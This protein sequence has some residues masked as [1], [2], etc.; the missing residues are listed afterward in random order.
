M[1]AML[2]PILILAL[3]LLAA[4]FVLAITAQSRARLATAFAELESQRQSELQLQAKL[5]EVT[6]S[7]ITPINQLPPEAFWPSRT[8]ADM[9]RA[10]QD[11]VLAAAQA[12]G[13]TVISFGGMGGDARC[14]LPCLTYEAELSGGHAEVADFLAAIE[15]V[16]PMLSTRMVWMRQLP[17][18]GIRAIA[19]INMRVSLWGLAPNIATAESD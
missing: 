8:L 1:K 5:A 10:I 16:S 19:P 15:T 9:E 17:P 7:N 13:L 14:T 12:T 4:L 18:D 11:A 2:R 6:S 3:C